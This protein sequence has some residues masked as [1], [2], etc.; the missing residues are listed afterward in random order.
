MWSSVCNCCEQAS[1]FSACLRV[2]PGTS[3]GAFQPPQMENRA[4]FSVWGQKAQTQKPEVSSCFPVWRRLSHVR[5][6]QNTKL[7]SPPPHHA[8]L[9]PLPS[10]RITV[11]AQRSDQA[12][13]LCLLFHRSLCFSSSSFHSLPSHK[14]LFP[15]VLQTFPGFQGIIVLCAC[16]RS[17]ACVCVCLMLFFNLQRCEGLSEGWV[18]EERCAERVWGP[19]CRDV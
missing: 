5:P 1:K 16:M 14:R 3:D 8:P 6:L 10:A 17:C 11:K 7:S 19:H 4:E 2:T 9:A 15:I 13:F 18:K 12:P